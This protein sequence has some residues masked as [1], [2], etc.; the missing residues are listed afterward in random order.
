[1]LTPAQI[2]LIQ[3][4]K[5]QL[6]LSD[7]D[8]RS[9]LENHGGARS[10]RDLDDRSFAAVMDRFNQLGFKSTSRAGSFG[11]RDGMATPAQV[12]L[13]RKLWAQW[14]SDPAPTHLDT[15]IAGRFKVSAL[16]FVPSA[17]APKVIAALSD[18]VVRKDKTDAA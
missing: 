11:D 8:Y 14:A 12:A 15:F 1:M 9:I 2:R 10:S 16:R 18:M 5:R 4:A 17:T 3:V 6:A 7:D 13:I